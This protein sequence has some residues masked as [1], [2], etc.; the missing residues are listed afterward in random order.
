MSQFPINYKCYWVC[1]LNFLESLVCFKLNEFIIPIQ[2]TY[3]Q[4]MS[5]TREIINHNCWKSNKVPRWLSINLYNPL[6]SEMKQCAR[7]EAAYSVWLAS[8]AIKARDTAHTYVLLKSLTLSTWHCVFNVTLAVK[9]QPGRGKPCY[10][11]I[12]HCLHLLGKEHVS[13]CPNFDRP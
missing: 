2:V 5:Y 1:I 11:S 10:F 13:Y 7:D 4:N 8:P 9:T 6:K 3:Y 12:Q